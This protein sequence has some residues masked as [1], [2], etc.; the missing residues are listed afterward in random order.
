MARL[1]PDVTSRIQDLLQD[2]N[3]SYSAI[4]HDLQLRRHTIARIHRCLKLF[5]TQYP[6]SGVVK[7]RPRA[8]TMAQEDVRDR[9]LLDCCIRLM[10][11]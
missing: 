9:A 7:G 10:L 5:N 11:M 6:P 8:L 1:A 3:Q 4:A 2:G